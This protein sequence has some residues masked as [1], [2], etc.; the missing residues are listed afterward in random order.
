MTRICIF[1]LCALALGCEP[2]CDPSEGG[3]ICTIVGSGDNGYDRG[4]DTTPIPALEARMSLPQDILARPD[5][6]L[7]ILDWNN[8]RL[9]ELT[10]E[11]DLRWIAG[12]GELGGSL[13]DPANGD[14]NHPTNI[15]FDETGDRVIMAAWHNS[16]IRIV[17]LTTGAVTDSCG[18]GRRAYFGDGGPAITASLDLPSSIALDPSGNLVILDQANQVIR[19]IDGAGNIDRIAGRCVID[20]PAPGGPGACADGVE[21]VACPGGSG[22]FTCGDPAEWCSRPCTPG[23]GGDEGP[24]LELRMGQPFGQSATPAGR[25]IYDAEGS[26]YFADTSNHLIRRIDPSGVV[27]R[28]AGQPPVGGVAQNGYSGDG[29]PA[30]EALLNYP[31]DLAFGDDGTLYFSDV[32]N[33]C[34]RAI[35]SDGIIERVAGTCGE[36]GY[37]GDR[38]PPLEAHFNLPFGIHWAAHRLYVADTGNSVIRVFETP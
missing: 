12:R 29:G 3:A 7:L 6:S 15:V 8:H 17:D 32:R 11:G 34:I 28:V 26:L 20:A 27:H 22:K 31:V 25:I 24:A 33:H 14:F 30:S 23:Y 19:R 5:G 4:A 10:T 18:D 2:P 13:D 9:R 1:T 16:K 21:P 37:D 35:R 36:S 38:G